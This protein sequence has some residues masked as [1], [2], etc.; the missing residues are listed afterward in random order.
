MP[1]LPRL[2]SADLYRDF[3]PGPGDQQ[4]PEDWSLLR[5]INSM[6]SEKFPNRITIAED[7]WNNK[8]ITTNR[9]AGKAGF[10]SQWN[11]NVVHPIR[12]VVI[13]SGN[14]QRSLS[15]IC[16][17]LCYR[18]NEDTFDRV[19]YSESHDDTTVLFFG[20]DFLHNPSN[21]PAGSGLPKIDK[22]RRLEMR[23]LIRWLQLAFLM[24]FVFDISPGFAASVRDDYIAGY[25]TAVVEREMRLAGRDLTVKDGVITISS[26]NLSTPDREKL[27][28]LLS[29]I[30]GVLRINIADPKDLAGTQPL[31]RT[32]TTIDEKLPVGFLPPS[33]LFKPLIADPH[34]PHFSLAYRNYLGDED[35][36]N[37]G[38]A[39]FGE[40]I[41]L[42]RSNGPFGGQWEMGLQA[43]VF[44][45]FDLD[46]NSLDLI[47]SDFFVGLFGS[48]RVGKFS[49]FSRLLHQSS[50]LGDQYQLRAGINNLSYEA[51]DLKLSYDFGRTLRVYGGGGVLFDQDP[52]D[53]KPWSTQIGAEL[54]S[55]WTYFGGL[56]TPIA[57]LDLQN[58]QEGHWRTDVSLRAGVEFAS[59][60]VL[61]RRLQLLFQYFN[62]RSPNGQFYGRAVQYLGLGLHLNL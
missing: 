6:V 15:T 62:G 21:S 54:R 46:S 32:T 38:S 13:T 28:V 16:N 19:I 59:P 30:P 57:G 20:Y 9:G 12:R 23:T 47:N 18:D 1:T 17:R 11:A 4:S 5:W 24:M 2:L 41:P 37:V 10:G 58:R 29:G 22:T 36:N 45:I 49:L 43:A 44:S 8:W 42:Y 50:H 3:A 52:S 34:W 25:A 33:Q 56:V 55:P 27:V 14:E 31:A 39:N 53:L 7:L 48:Y 35:L 60:Q 40:S 51:V 26:A 61:D